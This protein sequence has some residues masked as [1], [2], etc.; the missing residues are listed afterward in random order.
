MVGLLSALATRME[1]Q[2]NEKTQFIVDIAKIVFFAL[3]IIVPVR[4]FIVQPFF[5]EGAS[6]EP[7]YHDGDYL[8]VDKLSYL[9]G[10]PSRGDVIVFRFPQNP[11]KVFIKR[12]IGLPGETVVVDRGSVYIENAQHPEGFELEEVYL[13]E[14]TGQ[15]VRT[16][17]KDDEYFVMGD[18]RDASYDSRGWGSLN[19]R[20]IIGRVLL[21]AWPFAD[22]QLIASP[23]YPIQ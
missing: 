13:D 19:E 9:A 18:N 7:N 22:A 6:M 2:R 23:S 3:L 20:F 5:V 8:L 1:E 14:V 16:P 10:E 15:S 17:L 21:R 4:Y 11:D 12:V